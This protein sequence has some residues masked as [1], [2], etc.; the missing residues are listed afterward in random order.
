MKC[1]FIFLMFDL[2]MDDLIRKIRYHK[3]LNQTFI[4]LFFSWEACNHCVE[5]A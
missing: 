2:V 5:A 4:K 3:I 1:P